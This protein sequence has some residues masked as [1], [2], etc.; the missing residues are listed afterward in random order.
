MICMKNKIALTCTII[1]LCL[2]VGFV[3]KT[4]INYFQY[5]PLTNSAPFY[6]WILLNAI[7]FLLPALI[8]FV[9]GV[10]VRRAK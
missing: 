6:A 5:S 9:V 10:I 7:Y 1:S 3:V 2:V 8:V 4:V